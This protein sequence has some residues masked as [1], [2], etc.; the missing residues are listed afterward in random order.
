[1]ED[2]ELK[3][4]FLERGT[5]KRKDGCQQAEVPCRQNELT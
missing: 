5:G 1:M 4:V 2:A 3:S